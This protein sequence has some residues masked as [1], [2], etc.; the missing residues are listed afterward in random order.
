MKP[1][2]FDYA[3]PDTADEAV[4][5]LA[6]YG[7][8]ARV[9]AGGQSLIPMLNLRLLDVGVLIDISQLRD[10]GGIRDR[11]DTIEIGAAV[12]QNTLMA[13]P[14]L[15]EKLPL[16]ARGAAV[17]R[18]FPDPQQRHGLR[19]DRACRSKLGIAAVA[20]GARRRSGAALGQGRAR[21]SGERIS[22]GHAD[23]GAR[24]G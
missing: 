17:R 3:R 23:H 22:A 18:P 1:R 13:W 21:A 4:A 15:A 5:L 11:G 8:D 24:T 19:L 12:T 2:A 10:L 9:L 14:L 6:E 7:D 20:R 16:V